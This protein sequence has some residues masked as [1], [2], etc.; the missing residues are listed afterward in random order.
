[1][2]TKQQERDALE[3]IEKIL[4]S[5]DPDGYVN[6]AFAG[7]IEDARRNIDE[8]AAY[9]AAENVEHYRKIAETLDNEKAALEKELETLRGRVMSKGD[10]AQAH[11]LASKRVGA[12][13]EQIKQDEQTILATC[14]TPE[15]NS[16]HVAVNQREAALREI[17][18][19]TEYR[20]R[21]G[22]IL[23]A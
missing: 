21:I 18:D 2:T 22:A 3:K 19:L 1:M 4:K 12:L 14:A 7:C 8:D 6:T 17:N 15:C 20:D 23:G 13:Q 11:I 10:V 9:S 16:F 5:I